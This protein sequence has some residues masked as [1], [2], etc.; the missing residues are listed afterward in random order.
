[1]HSVGDENGGTGAGAGTCPRK[2]R[3][4][5]GEWLEWKVDVDE[6]LS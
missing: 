2:R 5:T 3:E 4:V 1:M 6:T